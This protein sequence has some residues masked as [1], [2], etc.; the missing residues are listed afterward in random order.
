MINVTENGIIYEVDI[1]DDGTKF[2]RLNG[3]LHRIGEPAIE[4]ADGTKYFYLNG[5]LHRENGPAI[6]WANGFKAYYLNGRLHRIG[7]PAVEY[8]NGDKRLY[9]NGINYTKDEYLN[10]IE[11]LNVIM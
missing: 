7:G 4:W 5:F 2:W 6:H 8:P 10:E 9:L 3:L 1:N 11:K